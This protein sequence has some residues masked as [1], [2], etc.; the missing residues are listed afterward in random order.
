MAEE[1]I[2]KYTFKK[3]IGIFWVIIF[4][5]AAGYGFHKYGCYFLDRKPFLS[6]IYFS[7]N[8]PIREDA[9]GE[10]D[11]GAKRKGRRLHLGVDIL[12][13]IGTPVYA[14]KCGLVINAETNSGLG[15][16]VEILH[17]DGLVTIYGHLSKIDV[18]Q[19]QRVCQ[20]DKIG[21]VGKTG[22]AR[23]RLIL[24]HLHFE[25]R[26]YGM[27]QDPILYLSSHNK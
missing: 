4:A 5:A 1:T 8:I 2:K 27:P 23:N 10:G 26:K 14:A 17:H 25:V 11:F 9:F 24:P 6:P 3:I 16:Y 20:G 19:G 22:N 15:M 21:A 13:T 12:A 18:Y 7:S